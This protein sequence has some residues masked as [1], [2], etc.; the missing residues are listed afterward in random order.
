MDESDKELL[1]SLK[2]MLMQT[3]DEVRRKIINNMKSGDRKTILKWLDE[4]C[5]GYSYHIIKN[6]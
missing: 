4:A 2:A 5:G 3:P 1:D 6:D